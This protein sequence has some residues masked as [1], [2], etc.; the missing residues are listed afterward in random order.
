[1][2]HS[3]FTIGETPAGHF[4]PHV[5]PNPSIA[6]K[7]IALKSLEHGA[8]ENTTTS[9]RITENNEIL[10]SILEMLANHYSSVDGSHIYTLA[11]LK[12]LYAHPLKLSMISSYNTLCIFTLHAYSIRHLLSVSGFFILLHFSFV[13]NICFYW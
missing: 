1:M 4:H 2:T 7:I 9:L 11:G 13:W 3:W 5:L 10:L 6:Q 12:C 8:K